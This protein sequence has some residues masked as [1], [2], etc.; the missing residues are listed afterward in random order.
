MSSGVGASGAH[1]QRQKQP[2][3]S[4]AAAASAATAAASSSDLA[5]GLVSELLAD[6]EVAVAEHDVAS[7]CTVLAAG[8]KML[9]VLTRGDQDA[10][11]QQQQQRPGGGQDDA[12]VLRDRLELALEEGRLVRTCIHSH[13]LGTAQPT[14]SLCES[15]IPLRP[16]P[17]PLPIFSPLAPPAGSCR[18]ARGSADPTRCQHGRGE[19]RLWPCAVLLVR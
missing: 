1:Q 2:R 9:I 6:L 8:D 17:R 18:P 15:S 3:H 10:L 12:A 7:A 11:Q 19:V 14:C 13:P 5:Q 16:R 4:T